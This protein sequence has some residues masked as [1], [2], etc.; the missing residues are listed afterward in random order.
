[1]NA[2]R[3]LFGYN[4]ARELALRGVEKR[5]ATEAENRALIRATARKMCVEV[6]RPV[7]SALEG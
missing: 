6:G 4:P 7:P 1:M 5:R 2:L 3:R